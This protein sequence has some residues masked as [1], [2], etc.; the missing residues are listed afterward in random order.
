MNEFTVRAMPAQGLDRRFRAGRPWG[1][2]P[3]NIKVVD[4]PTPTRIE[5]DRDGREMR[6]YSDEISPKDLEALRADPHFA[7]VPVGA[8]DGAA[9]EVNAAKAEVIKL[10]GELEAARRELQGV[11]EDHKMFQSASLKDAEEK[12]ALIAKLQN[13]LAAAQSSASKRRGG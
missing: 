8:N 5:K 6:T 13:D 12:G 1:K 10:A 4:N 7:V 3:V 2:N 9:L 11:V